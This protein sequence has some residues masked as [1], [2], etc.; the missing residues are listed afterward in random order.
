MEEGRP[1]KLSAPL[2]WTLIVLAYAFL[3]LAVLGAF[4][5]ILPTTPFVLVAAFLFSK[6]SPRLHL[7]LTSMPYFGNAIIEW[8]QHRIIRMK[9]KI[10]AISLICIT[11]GYTILLTDLRIELKIGLAILGSLVTTFIGTRKSKL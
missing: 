3:G 8:E 5:P 7:W 10:M 6:A 4:L 11:F 9:A 1:I 2:R